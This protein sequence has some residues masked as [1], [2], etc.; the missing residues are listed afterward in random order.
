MCLKACRPPFSP[1]NRRCAECVVDDRLYLDE[2]CRR[3]RQRQLNRF[4][5]SEAARFDQITPATD[6]E[7]LEHLGQVCPVVY[8]ESEFTFTFL[9]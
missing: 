4:L 9:T 8:R 2:L 3:H 1:V 5:A 6:Q 7:Y